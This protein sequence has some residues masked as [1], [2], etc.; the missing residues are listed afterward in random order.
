M[1][2]EA[3]LSSRCRD[4]PLQSLGSHIRPQPH[5]LGLIFIVRSDYQNS[6]H[7]AAGEVAGYT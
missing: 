6:S 3:H 5:G 2:F 7:R 4:I 1:N